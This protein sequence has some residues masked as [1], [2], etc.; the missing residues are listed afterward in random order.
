MDVESDDLWIIETPFYAVEL[1]DAPKLLK[2]LVNEL[3]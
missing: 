2:K 3:S 1:E